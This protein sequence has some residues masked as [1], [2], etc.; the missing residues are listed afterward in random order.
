MDTPRYSHQAVIAFDVKSDNGAD[1]LTEQ[2]LLIALHGRLYDL[3]P[4]E[5][6]YAVSIE[7]TYDSKG[8]PA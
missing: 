1:D 4:G 5:I 3:Q 7:E 2:E 6:K 8:E